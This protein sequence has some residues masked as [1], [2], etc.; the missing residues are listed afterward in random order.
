MLTGI[1]I[2]LMVAM[3]GGMMLVGHKKMGGGHQNHAKS[4]PHAPVEISSAPVQGV[5]AGSGGHGQHQH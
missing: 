1:G 4:S 5:E 2:A 3:M